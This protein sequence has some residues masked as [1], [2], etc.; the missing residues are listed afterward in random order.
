MK[1]V[2]YKPVQITP[3]EIVGVAIVVPIAIAGIYYGYK[4]YKAI[5]G[6]LAPIQ[7][8]ANAIWNARPKIIFKGVDDA[9]ISL[10]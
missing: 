5:K 3:V 8:P 2:E 1:L 7:D 9:I 4:A 10:M 6:V